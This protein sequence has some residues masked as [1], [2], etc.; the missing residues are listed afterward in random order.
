MSSG[1]IV[2]KRFRSF[3][4]VSFVVSLAAVLVL[5]IVSLPSLEQTPA[6]RL[7]L[8]GDAIPSKLLAVIRQSPLSIWNPMQHARFDVDR[9][10]CFVVAL[11]ALPHFKNPTA[12]L[13]LHETSV[14]SLAGI[15][16]KFPKQSID[17]WIRVEGSK[18]LVDGLLV[19]SAMQKAYDGR[20]ATYAWLSKSPFG[21]HVS[22]AFTDVVPESP[23][24]FH[25]GQL[26]KTLGYAGCSSDTVVEASQGYVGV[27]RD[28]LTDMFM[29]YTP[30]GE[31]EFFAIA[32]AHYLPP[33]RNWTNKFGDTYS[34]DSLAINLVDTPAGV[35]A[36]GG[37]HVPIAV[38]AILE[39]H[40]QF[41]ILSAETAVR[42]QGYLRHVTRILES[43]QDTLGGWSSWGAE[44]DDQSKT[45]DLETQTLLVTAHHL[46][47]ISLSA[48]EVS[49]NREVISRAINRAL[50]IVRDMRDRNRSFKAQLPLLHFLRALTA[51]CHEHHPMDFL[52]H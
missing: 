40:R 42:C 25:F 18:S 13:A 8:R 31:Q 17:R 44:L 36:C 12:G 33:K 23:S 10:S 48:P 39:A 5:P 29:N 47:W 19:E 41:S 37:I 30:D 52:R 11:E 45:L 9:E 4:C 2:L 43:R 22:Q 50:G 14:W 46:E 51:L 38:A 49:P 3:K 16:E 1:E 34:F 21:I 28:V 35:G 32:A 7:G 15:D 26:G 24:E 27:V 20:E 6:A